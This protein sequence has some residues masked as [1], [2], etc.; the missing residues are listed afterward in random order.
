M[1]P[2]EKLRRRKSASGNIGSRVAGLVRNE[3]HEQ[4]HAENERDDHGR[5]APA[6]ARLLDQREH[7]PAETQRAEQAAE[8][9]DRS[10]T[11]ASRRGFWDD[12]KDQ[13]HAD[14]DERQVDEE[15]HTPRG[16]L[17][18][19]APGERA[20]HRGDPSPSGPAAD[21]GTAL[22]LAEGGDDHRQRARREQRTGH[23]L[24]RPRRDQRPDRWRQRA[25]QRGDTEPADAERED[26]PL[27]VQ[28]AQR[29]ADQDQRAER[30][31]VGVHDPLLS[32]ETAAELAL[33]R[34]QG[35]VHHRAVEQSYTRTEDASNEREPLHLGTVARGHE[36][37]VARASQTRVQALASA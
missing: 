3:A 12:R 35:D 5:A 20:K 19:L 34:R 21:R 29:A 28:V 22:G 11:L 8:E 26:P 24:Q 30:E 17:Q 32:R 15:D 33:D 1:F 37:T 10:G 9:V 25:Q 7:R 31:Q 27:A 4:R 36:S 13:R 23:P 2:A 6:Q 16:D 14:E 18:E